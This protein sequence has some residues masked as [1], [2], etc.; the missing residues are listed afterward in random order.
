MSF[1]GSTVWKEGF[2][3]SYDICLVGV[4]GRGFAAWWELPRPSNILRKS[5]SPSASYGLLTW[6][7][8]S[9]GLSCPSSI[10]F[11][12]SNSWRSFTQC[13]SIWVNKVLI[14]VISFSNY[15]FES[16]AEI[17]I[18]MSPGRILFPMSSGV[19]APE[20]F[21][22]KVRRCMLMSVSWLVVL[23]F[24]SVMRTWSQR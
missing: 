16:E 5:N 1:F 7:K 6:A 24:S 14:V 10:D 23:T 21:S 13:F 2:V 22:Y 3:Y 11:R 8:S 4:T 15:A 19:K 12:L 17:N 9:S 20:I 18:G